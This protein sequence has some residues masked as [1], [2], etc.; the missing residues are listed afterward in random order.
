MHAAITEIN[1][2][3]SAKRIYA[4][5][6]RNPVGMAF[7]PTTGKLWAAVQGRDRLGDNLVPG[8]LAEVQ[9]GANKIWRVSHGRP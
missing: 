5:G 1:P 4:S 8:Y 3:G 6:P 7:N 2:D 9:D